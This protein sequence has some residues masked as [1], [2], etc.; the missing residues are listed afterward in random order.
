MEVC[1]AV[2]VPPTRCSRHTRVASARPVNRARAT[3]V[4]LLTL[5]WAAQSGLCLRASPARPR[6]QCTNIPSVS[7]QGVAFVGSYSVT[8][9][10]HQRPRPRRRRLA[11][12][13]VSMSIS[14]RHKRPRPRCSRPRY[15]DHSMRPVPDISGQGREPTRA[16]SRV[17]Q[18]PPDG[19][20]RGTR[21]RQKL[22]PKGPT[23]SVV[24]LSAGS[25]H[26]GAVTAAPLD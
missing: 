16:D 13:L 3:R 11:H 22:G 12:R 14:P 5:G 26:V 15:P 23:P 4:A 19:A 18:C 2:A 24:R 20:V 17:F 10:I 6:L 1:L 25:N 7:V 9:P 21:P 8:R